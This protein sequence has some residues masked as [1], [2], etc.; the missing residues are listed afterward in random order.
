MIIIGTLNH[1]KNLAAIKIFLCN[2]VDH[3]I[4]IYSEL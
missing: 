1:R 3:L 4:P 2:I